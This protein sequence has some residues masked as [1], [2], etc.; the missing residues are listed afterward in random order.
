V[1][2]LEQQRINFEHRAHL[3]R[4]NLYGHSTQAEAPRGWVDKKSW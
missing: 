2:R 4:D 3:V 1:E